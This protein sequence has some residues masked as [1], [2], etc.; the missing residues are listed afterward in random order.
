M[1]LLSVFYVSMQWNKTMLLKIKIIMSA[2]PVD[3]VK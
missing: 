2:E 3:M 1:V